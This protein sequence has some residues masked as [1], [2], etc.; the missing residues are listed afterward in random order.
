MTAFKGKI[1][2][3]VSPDFAKAYENSLADLDRQA[4]KMSADADRLQKD[5]ET[6]RGE[7]IKLRSSGENGE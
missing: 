7:L 2:E 3:T 4:K 5:Y 6:M 1:F